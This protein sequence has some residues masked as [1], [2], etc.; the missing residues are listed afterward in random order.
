MDFFK[1]MHI[2]MKLA[3]CGTL[4]DDVVGEGH[5]VDYLLFLMNRMGNFSYV[6]YMKLGDFG[7]QENSRLMLTR[8]AF[9]LGYVEDVRDLDKGGMMKRPMYER[10]A[11]RFL[12]GF[13]EGHFGPCLLDV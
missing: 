4:K 1:D 12:K 5:I 3:A 10:I 6:D 9:A 8:S 13:R 11:L 2:G 7:P